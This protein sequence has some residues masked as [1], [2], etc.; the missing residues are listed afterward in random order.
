VC[1]DG[2]ATDEDSATD[3]TD[4]V[5]GDASEASADVGVD[6]APETAPDDTHAADAGD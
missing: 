3:A 5:E 1:S 2:C 6:G 4:D